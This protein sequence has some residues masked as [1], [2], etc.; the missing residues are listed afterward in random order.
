M[1][2]TCAH[3]ARPL[4]AWLAVTGGVPALFIRWLQG[5][6]GCGPRQPRNISANQARFLAAPG[7]NP[8]NPGRRMPPNQGSERA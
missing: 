7:W 4:L 1:A 5:P 2:A 3:V 8:V 6:R